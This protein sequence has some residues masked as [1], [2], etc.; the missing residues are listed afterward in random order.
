[1]TMC[2]KI[3][4]T[5]VPELQL[6]TLLAE[7][8]CARA[9]RTVESQPSAYTSEDQY[10]VG[11]CFYVTGEYAKSETVMR[12]L[13][14]QPTLW[15]DVRTKVHY[16][17]A[18]LSEHSNRLDEARQFYEQVLVA[19]PDSLESLCYNA[20]LDLKQ[21]GPP[22]EAHSVIH[23]I[24][25]SNSAS[26]LALKCVASYA[27]TNTT[28]PDAQ[29]IAELSCQQM[30]AHPKTAE[31]GWTCLA[32]NIRKWY[33]DDPGRVHAEL[34][35]LNQQ[36]ERALRDALHH[37]PQDV[38]SLT[39]LADYLTKAGQP[40][41]AADIFEVISTLETHPDAQA[42]ALEKAASSYLLAGAVELA[43]ATWARLKVIP[44]HEDQYLRGRALVAIAQL[45]FE[46]AMKILE[47]A[48]MVPSPLHRLASSARIAVSLS[49]KDYSRVGKESAKAFEQAYVWCDAHLKLYPDDDTVMHSYEYVNWR[50]KE[51]S[52]QF[53]QIVTER[54]D[55]I[56]NIGRQWN[57]RLA[58]VYLTYGALAY[59]HRGKGYQTRPDMAAQ[60]KADFN[61][62]EAILM[63]V[64]AKKDEMLASGD[65]L[66][67]YN[68]MEAWLSLG[69]SKYYRGD[70]E[71]ADKIFS[72]VVT[73]SEWD[74]DKNRSTDLYDWPR[75][76]ILPKQLVEAYRGVGTSRDR[77]ARNHFFKKAYETAD[78]V[79]AEAVKSL[80]SG[81]AL[82][83][84]HIDAAPVQFAHALNLGIV[85]GDPDVLRDEQLAITAEGYVTYIHYFDRAVHTESIF[86]LGV[87]RYWHAKILREWKKMDLA[88][89]AYDAAEADLLHVVQVATDH[90]ESYRFLEYIAAIHKGDMDKA[91]F[92]YKEAKKYSTE[93]P[94]DA[95]VKMVDGYDAQLNSD[96]DASSERE[97]RRNMV[98]LSRLKYAIALADASSDPR[99][100]QR[101]LGY[102]QEVAQSLICDASG[103]YRAQLVE[104]VEDSMRMPAQASDFERKRLAQ[105]HSRLLEVLR[106]CFAAHNIS[107]AHV[108]SLTPSQR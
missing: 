3:T 43:D 106:P 64:M 42:N 57:N 72:A 70:F 97:A 95:L 20:L 41:Q 49:T 88:A 84:Q 73:A 11:K 56:I 23:Y 26:H 87:A 17:L 2:P 34:A 59:A 98:I 14:A 71:A 13:L 19:E 67:V 16:A 66:N 69:W 4:Q 94:V 54:T 53:D 108:V 82:E 60:A 77:L 92:Y 61:N 76:K 85:D 8:S 83:Q 33:Q 90:A 46:G 39:A 103:V 6:S 35:V 29:T 80:E 27:R 22:H 91:E 24:L 31:A 7:G 1:M 10:Q 65:V 104:L 12:Q 5:L 32:D 86:N 37:N 9:Q 75:Q 30:F 36:H 48:K 15:A 100:L 101:A 62:A 96:V 50:A 40:A 89:T 93:Q 38:S 21:G 55:R 107:T 45:R 68:L 58:A 74:A 47:D 52:G 18:K 28:W 51:A 78:R 105:N 79:E 63:E 102:A 81:L 99:W 44:G 25:N